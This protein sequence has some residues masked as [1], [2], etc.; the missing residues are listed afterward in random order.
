MKF[1][2]KL[3]CKYRLKHYQKTDFSFEPE[4]VSKYLY[5]GVAAMAD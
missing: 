4:L 5:N 3:Q 2:F 1:G